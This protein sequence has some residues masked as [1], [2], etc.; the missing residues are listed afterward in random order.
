[1][2]MRELSD[3]EFIVMNNIKRGALAIYD[4]DYNKVE[5]CLSEALKYMYK[6]NP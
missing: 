4:G 6:I 1:M 2:A 5:A 3:Y